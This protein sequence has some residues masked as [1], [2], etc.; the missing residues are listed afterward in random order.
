MDTGTTNLLLDTELEYPND[1]YIHMNMIQEQTCMEVLIPS[2]EVTCRC[3]TCYAT[4]R[5]IDW[6][7]A[8]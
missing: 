4:D 5:N 7:V 3:G 1:C 8:D 6:N 2:G